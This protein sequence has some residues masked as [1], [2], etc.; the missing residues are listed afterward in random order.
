MP[1]N[2][3]PLSTS[4]RYG[5]LD[6]AR[7]NGLILRTEAEREGFLGHIMHALYPAEGFGSF[8]AVFKEGRRRMPYPAF[9]DFSGQIAFLKAK[10][11][12]YDGR[13]LAESVLRS[14]R[15]NAGGRPGR[16]PRGARRHELAAIVATGFGDVYQRF[17]GRPACHGGRATP[18][19]CEKFIEECV[20]VARQRVP[21]LPSP[22][23]KIL[24]R[25]IEERRL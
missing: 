5:Y 25:A 13:L 4:E 16:W 19:A 17:A 14:D 10:S 18:S 6:A 22:S 12:Y 2:Q 15:D 20:L 21:G 24:R 11:G 9:L 1:L 7:H 3:E 8:E 23:R